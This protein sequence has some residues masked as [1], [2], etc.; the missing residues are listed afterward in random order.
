MQKDRLFVES[1]IQNH[2]PEAARAYCLSLFR[3]YSFTFLLKPE[4]RS[5]LGNYRYVGSTDT[6]IISVNRTLNPH[7]FLVT[8]LHEVAHL[9]VKIRYKRRPQPHGREWKKCFSELLQPVLNTDVFPSEILAPLREYA[10]NPK[11]SSLSDKRLAE[12]LHPDLSEGDGT[13]IS[14]IPDQVTFKFRDR[15]FLKLHMKR[16]RCLCKD[17]KSGR[18]YLISGSLR[19]EICA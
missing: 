11:A 10:K 19:A 2:V 13:K 1:F 9:L 15:V 16:S 4:R 7:A 5:V 18:N 8:Y 14:E 12:V 6:H 17:I 3:G